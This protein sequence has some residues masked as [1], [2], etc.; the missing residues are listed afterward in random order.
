MTQSKPTS[1]RNR[2]K[3]IALERVERLLELARQIFKDRP[4]LA[5]R[6]VELAWRLKTR[7]NLKLPQR[8]KLKFCRKCRSP[9]IPGVTCRVRTR[10][11]RPPHVVITCLQCS[12]EKRIPYKPR[13]TKKPVSKPNEKH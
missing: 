12:Y 8:L 7:H 5:H 6:Y 9:W 11:K 10:A 3:A 4:K 2:Q 13:K 1:R